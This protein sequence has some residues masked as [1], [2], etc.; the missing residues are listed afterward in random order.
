[1]EKKKILVVYPEMLVG[2]STTS[3]L[4]FLNC[5]DKEKYEVDLPICKAVYGILYE[6]GNPADALESLFKRDTKSEF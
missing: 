6:N 1:M 4:A 5:I 3:L 2:G